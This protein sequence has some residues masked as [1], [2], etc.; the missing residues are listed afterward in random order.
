MVKAACLGR[1][2]SLVNRA[3][4]VPQPSV[5]DR[6]AP[7]ALASDRHRGEPARLRILRTQRAM[8][9]GSGTGTAHGRLVPQLFRAVA[10]LKRTLVRERTLAELESARRRERRTAGRF[11]READPRDTGAIP[12][13][14]ETRCSTAQATSMFSK[15]P[16]VS[17]SPRFQ[18]RSP[19]HLRPRGTRSGILKWS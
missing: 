7:L 15:A 10:E 2:P 5:D 4:G 18:R 3:M 8:R 1:Q 11:L 19:T 17:E 14:I 12:H 6:T 13:A 16:R 9:Y